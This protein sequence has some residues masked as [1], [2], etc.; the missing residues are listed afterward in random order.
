MTEALLDNDA[1]IIINSV[2]SLT[3]SQAGRYQAKVVPFNYCAGGKLC[4]HGK[5]RKKKDLNCADL[6]LTPI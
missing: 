1:T 2:T 5:E 3:S 6:G 4:P